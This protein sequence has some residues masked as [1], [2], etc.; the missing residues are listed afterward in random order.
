MESVRL[1]NILRLFA[2]INTKKSCIYYTLKKIVQN[3]YTYITKYKDGGLF[4]KKYGI[5]EIIERVINFAK[6][7]F[8][9][10]NLIV[11]YYIIINS[12][13]KVCIHYF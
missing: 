8:N 2:E 13:E 4:L 1:G 10:G 9:K 7:I 6:T 11:K 12:V 5:K 3:G